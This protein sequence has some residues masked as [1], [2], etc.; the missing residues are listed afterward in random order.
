MVSSSR[1]V[2]DTEPNPN[3]GTPPDY[4]YFLFTDEYNLSPRIL[5]HE[6]EIPGL[7]PGENYYCRII[8]SNGSTTVFEEVVCS[9]PEEEEEIKEEGEVLG[10]SDVII[11]EA[12]PKTGH[13][14]DTRIQNTIFYLYD[15]IS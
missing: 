9:M 3:W 15:H 7:V 1:V 14:K 13:G 12:L 8:S 10:E 6:V 11:P 2:C 4:G 5:N